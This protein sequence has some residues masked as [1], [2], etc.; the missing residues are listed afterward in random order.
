[1]E[2]TIV[3]SAKEAEEAERQAAEDMK[4]AGKKV[5]RKRRP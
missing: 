2:K 5:I 3:R 4:A 1:L